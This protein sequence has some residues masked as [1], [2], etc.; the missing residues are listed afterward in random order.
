MY[1]H[2]HIQ[3]NK[4]M[5][6]CCETCHSKIFVIH[7]SKDHLFIYVVMYVSKDYLYVCFVMHESMMIYLIVYF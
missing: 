4:Y 3:M 6:E 1:T 7:V 2:T 5:G